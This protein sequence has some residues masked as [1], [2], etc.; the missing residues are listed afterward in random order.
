[1]I[2]FHGPLIPLLDE[3]DVGLPSERR[4]S[5]GKLRQ[6]LLNPLIGL[7]NERS[8]ALD[9]SCDHRCGDLR[10]VDLHLLFA[11]RD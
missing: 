6:L 8:R 3:G 10:D 7:K 11:L 2:H 4:R 1:M 5:M 9:F